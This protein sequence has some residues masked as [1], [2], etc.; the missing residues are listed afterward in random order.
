MVA[1]LIIMHHTAE[2]PWDEYIRIAN[3]I[4]EDNER[5]VGAYRDAFSAGYRPGSLPHKIM[6]RLRDGGM[7]DDE[8]SKYLNQSS[9]APSKPIDTAPPIMPIVDRPS[10]LESKIADLPLFA[11]SAHAMP[12]AMDVPLAD[13]ADRAYMER[14]ATGCS[15]KIAGNPIAASSHRINYDLAA[16]AVLSDWSGSRIPNSEVRKR[17]SQLRR[18]G[19][20]VPEYSAASPGWSYHRYMEAR[21]KLKNEVK[22]HASSQKLS[23]IDLA[24]RKLV[25]P[26]AR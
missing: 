2:N 14:R 19:Y 8:I 9:P 5:F 20:N 12:E 1:I 13:D 15:T 22:E 6:T 21:A 10:D 7:N 25:D 16:E 24:N 17:L 3:S 11:A 4:H 26:W 23:E 18:A